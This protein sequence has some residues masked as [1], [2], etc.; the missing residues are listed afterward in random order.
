MEP[1][2][3]K[4]FRFLALPGEIRNIIYK[5]VLCTTYP[6][7][8]SER[9]RGQ[10]VADIVSVRHSIEPQLLRVSKQVYKEANDV[11][12]KTN[13]FIRITSNGV[14]SFSH[15]LLYNRI[16]ILTLDREHTNAFKGCV[17]HHTISCP[18]QFDPFFDFM[19]LCRDLDMFCQCLGEVKRY[20]WGF[21]GFNGKSTVRQTITLLN[22]FDSPTYTEK[23]QDSLLAPYRT[24]FDFPQVEINVAVPISVELMPRNDQESSGP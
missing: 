19:I 8:H 18:G 4:P 22:P 12:L 20:W 10:S 9:P 14:D 5:I 6:P 3:A 17:L 21:Y 13:L 15:F 2:S 16:P 11:M 24:H 23:L 1:V 7:T